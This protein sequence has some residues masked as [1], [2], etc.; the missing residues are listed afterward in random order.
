MKRPRIRP[1]KERNPVAVGV[2]GLLVIALTP[3]SLQRAAA[4][5][6]GTAAADFVVRP[7]GLDRAHEVVGPRQPQRDQ[8]RRPAA[9]AARGRCGRRHGRCGQ[10]GERGGR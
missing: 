4:V 8:R 1:V 10:D 7:Y 5:R 3:C 9:A 6:G 2:A